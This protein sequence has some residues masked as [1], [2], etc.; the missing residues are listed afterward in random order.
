MDTSARRGWKEANKDSPAI[1]CIKLT[2]SSTKV[3]D[4]NPG[5]KTPEPGGSKVKMPRFKRFF[6]DRRGGI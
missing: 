1:G 6:P 2:R 4:F 3:K 5:E